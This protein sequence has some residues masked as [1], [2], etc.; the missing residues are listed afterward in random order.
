M[1]AKFPI[2]DDPSFDMGWGNVRRR[3]ETMVKP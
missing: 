3:D 1:A 2:K